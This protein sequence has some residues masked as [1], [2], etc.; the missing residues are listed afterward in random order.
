MSRTAERCRNPLIFYLPLLCSI[1]F[2]LIISNYLVKLD[3]TVTKDFIIAW[4]NNQTVLT[5]EHF[6]LTQFPLLNKYYYFLDFIGV[7]TTL[8][9]QYWE[10][11]LAKLGNYSLVFELVATGSFCCCCV[12]LAASSRH[13]SFIS[14]V[15]LQ[16]A[17][18]L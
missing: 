16:P 5:F 12:Q 15:D 3:T 8:Q 7:F 11:S 9:L 13:R 6:K 2:S 4:L 14:S 17:C 1:S 18:Q 10:L